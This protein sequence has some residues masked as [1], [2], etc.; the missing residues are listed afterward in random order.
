MRSGRQ[1][2]CP[3]AGEPCQ[4][5]CTT[6]CGSNAR[7]VEEL[8]ML[9]RKLV[10]QLRKAAPGNKSAEKA[11]DYLKRKGLAGRVLR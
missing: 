6:P 4:S 9:V 10:Q 3:T 11:L 7:Q 2:Y 5:V 8:A 1:D